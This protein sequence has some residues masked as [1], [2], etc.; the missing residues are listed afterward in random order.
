M[1]K[2][3]LSSY[4]DQWSAHKKIIDLIFIIS[5][6]KSNLMKQWEEICSHRAYLIS[7]QQEDPKLRGSFLAEIY[8][9][10]VTNIAFTYFK[11]YNMFNFLHTFSQYV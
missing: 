7:K 1:L 2:S 4:P 10:K 5:D 9:I 6:E 3:I 8:L 11:D